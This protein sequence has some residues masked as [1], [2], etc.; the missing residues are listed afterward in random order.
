VCVCVCVCVWLVAYCMI[1]RIL[2][3]VKF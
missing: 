3:D 1:C 2:G